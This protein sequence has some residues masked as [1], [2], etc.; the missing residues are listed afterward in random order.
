MIEHGETNNLPASI[1]RRIYTTLQN[2]TKG[3]TGL[4]DLL[5]PIRVKTGSIYIW[6][7]SRT[8]ISNLAN[9]LTYVTIYSFAPFD[10]V[11]R[12]E[13]FYELLLFIYFFFS[14]FWTITIQWRWGRCYWHDTR[15]YNPSCNKISKIEQK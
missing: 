7:V 1:I 4:D 5:P 15:I 9:Y 10:F 8:H 12:I 11:Y 13:I 6:P 14:I 2:C 3:S